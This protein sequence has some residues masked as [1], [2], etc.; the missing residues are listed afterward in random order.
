M[1]L[2]FSLQV[3]R[4]W[5]QCLYAP[6]IWTHLYVN[7]QMFIRM[8]YQESDGSSCCI[9]DYDRAEQWLRHVGHFIKHIQFEPSHEF[10]CLYQLLTLLVWH[11]N[12]QV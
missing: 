4:N 6:T 11:M 12:Q 7:D 5:N 8:V 9:F 3:C 2:N 1:K 10:T